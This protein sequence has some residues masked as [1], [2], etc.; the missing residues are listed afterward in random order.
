MSAPG[1]F[2]ELPN[3]AQ[4]RMVSPQRIDGFI[5]LTIPQSGVHQKGAHQHG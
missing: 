4:H 3:R 5:L 1:L 2:G